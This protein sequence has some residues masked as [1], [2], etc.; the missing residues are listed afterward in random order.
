[1]IHYFF[2]GLGYFFI[3]AGIFVPSMIFFIR[4]NK[5]NDKSINFQKRFKIFVSM[6][7]AMSPILA[8]GGLLVYF[9]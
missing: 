7:I 2:T 3:F 1:M 4:S 9:Y 6:F 5:S 8:I